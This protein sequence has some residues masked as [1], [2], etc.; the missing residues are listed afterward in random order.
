MNSKE[1]NLYCPIG[2]TGYGITSSNIAQY[3]YSLGIDISL[4]PIGQIG[5]NN[6]AEKNFFSHLVDN[7]KNFNYNA[8][9][10]KIWHQFDLASKIGNSHYYTYPF[11]ELDKFNNQEIHHLNYSNYIFTATQWSKNI[12]L[13]NGIKKPIYVAP[14]GVDTNIFKN[15]GLIKI[16]K[17]SYVFFHLGKWELRKA[18][19]FLIKAFSL[20]FN[21]NDNVELR[22]VPQVESLPQPYKE[23]M[24]KTISACHIN[25]KIKV[26][27]R[28]PTQYDLAKFIWDGDCGVFPSRAEGWNNEI[29][30]T[31][32]LNKPVITTNY[33]AHTEYCNNNN[34]MLIDIDETENANDGV[35][36]HGQGNWAKLGQKQLEQTINYMRH[37]YHNNIKTNE[38]G[39]ITAKQYSWK[40]TSSIIHDTLVTNG[41]FYANPKKKKRRR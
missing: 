36:F 23:H 39:L 10:L 31:M 5:V 40:N 3:L 7:S 19:D 25:E 20:A 1:L 29:L 17:P 30:E 32:A 22:L 2:H 6:D 4:F 11:F 38:Y 33:S 37:V 12:L 26:Y 28:L 13:Q 8:P 34:C 16:E 35:W 41:S 9:C 15:P 18:Q 27:T 14:L 24:E 21:K